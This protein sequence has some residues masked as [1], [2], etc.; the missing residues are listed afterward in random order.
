MGAK[1][2]L[3]TGAGGGVVY[4]LMD[5]QIDKCTFADPKHPQPH[6]HSETLCKTKGTHNLEK[7]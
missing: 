2:R 6:D 3:D 4:T 1:S 5:P 7:I